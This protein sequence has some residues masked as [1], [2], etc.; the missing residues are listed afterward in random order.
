MVRGARAAIGA[1]RQ[2]QGQ[3]HSRAGSFD[4]LAAAE[5]IGRVKCRVLF[6]I[7]SFLT[8]LVA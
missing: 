1:S 3:H 8:D 7:F 2:N 4:E 6:H 5:G